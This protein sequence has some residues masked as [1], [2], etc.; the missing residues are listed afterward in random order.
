MYGL[1]AGH[2]QNAAWVL[3]SLVLAA[4]AK[5]KDSTG[6]YLLTPAVREGDPETM[7]GKRVVVAEDM[8]NVAAN[9]FPI[10]FGDFKAG[11]II[12]DIPSWWL[13]RDEIT[14]PGYVKFP[15]SRRVGGKLLDTNAIKLLKIAAS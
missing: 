13:L 4:H 11:Y 6:Q 1:K 14:T 7:L 10:A 8:P 9:A 15:M 3:N 2:R 5:V 12:A